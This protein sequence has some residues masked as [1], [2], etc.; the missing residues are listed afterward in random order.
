MTMG[1]TAGMGAVVTIGADFIVTG[2]TVWTV[3]GENGT[4]FPWIGFGRIWIPFDFELGTLI[5]TDDNTK[6]VISYKISIKME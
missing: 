1:A 6:T 5:W 4:K 2:F 3:T